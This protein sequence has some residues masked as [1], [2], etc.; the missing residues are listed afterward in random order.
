MVVS[1]MI[2]SGIFLSPSG[3]LTQ[4]DSMGA[5]LCIW[6]GC[7]VLATLSDPFVLLE[8][9]DFELRQN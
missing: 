1:S 3:I 8:N 2:G 4:V 5:S 6:D 7:G 9:I